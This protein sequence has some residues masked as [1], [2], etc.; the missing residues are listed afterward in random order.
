LWWESD[1]G[2]TFIWVDDGNTQQWVQ[3][4][5]MPQTSGG[6]SFMMWPAGVGVDWW[7]LLAPQGTLFCAGQAVSRV[8]YAAL[9]SAIGTQFGAGD[10]S[11]TFLLPDARG[12]TTA[13]KDNMGG[14]AANRLTA[15]L[16]IGAAGGAETHALITAELAAHAHTQQ[17]TFGSGGQSVNHTHAQ[18]F[19]S[20]NATGSSKPFYN[21]GS[22]SDFGPATSLGSVDH[23]HSTTISGATTNTGSGTAHNNTQ[24]TIVCNKLIT[25]GGVA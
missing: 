23:T 13:G 14:T 2:N 24:P 17:G 7:G 20:G 4:N 5:V 19:S 1:S 10:G 22:G 15:L 11:T 25:T 9:F 16:A 8:T 3:Q 18:T 21:S 6:N 12:R